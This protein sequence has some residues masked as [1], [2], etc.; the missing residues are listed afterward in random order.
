MSNYYRITAYHPTEDY[1]FIVDSNGR[2]EKL[3]QFSAYLIGKG[4]KVI[5]VANDDTF[6][7]G[8]IPRGNPNG[9]K[10]YIQACTKGKPPII[11]LTVD[12]QVYRAIEIGGRYYVPSRR[13]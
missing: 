3:W 4:L 5:E 1:S 13:E 2:F 11:S 7:D 6:L 12:G 10:L 9:E 8:N